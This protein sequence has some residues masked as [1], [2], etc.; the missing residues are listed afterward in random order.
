MKATSLAF[1]AGIHEIVKRAFLSSRNSFFDNHLVNIYIYI[2]LS[3]YCLRTLNLVLKDLI[4]FIDDF[5]K[6]MLFDL[7]IYSDLTD[8]KYTLNLNDRS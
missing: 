1:T 8:N 5:L 2:F 7:Y 6:E 3:G 4:V